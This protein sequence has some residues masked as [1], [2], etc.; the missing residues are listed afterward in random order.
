MGFEVLTSLKYRLVS[1]FTDL[2][3]SNISNDKQFDAEP[4]KNNIHIKK[5]ILGNTAINNHGT[6]E[7]KS[8][9]SAKEIVN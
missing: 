2:L 3:S 4:C 1:F 9:D 7:I 8:D 5:I 6:E